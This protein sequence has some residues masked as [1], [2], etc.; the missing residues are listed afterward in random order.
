MRKS[1][2]H[3]Q[4]RETQRSQQVICYE[5]FSI[6]MHT[7]VNWYCI[8]LR[9]K[10]YLQLNV[11]CGCFF[12]MKKSS[13]Y[14]INFLS[15]LLG[16]FKK[17]TWSWQILR[18]LTWMREM[19]PVVFGEPLV[20]VSAINFTCLHHVTYCTILTLQHYFLINLVAQWLLS[21]QQT[22]LCNRPPCQ[23]PYRE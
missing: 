9:V 2:V 23:Q 6:Y 17:V 19:Y 8:I 21:S 5:N 3:D 1:D 18:S 15:V 12:H 14:F 4:K 20:K 22:F 11:F 10:R 7:P 16:G 13:S